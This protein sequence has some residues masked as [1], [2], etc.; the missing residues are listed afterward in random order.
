MYSF[1]NFWSGF[2]E[3]IYLYIFRRD[4]PKIF[5]YRLLGFQVYLFNLEDVKY[6][7]YMFLFV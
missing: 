1:I 6:V 3:Y 4:F 2:A 7:N 5:I